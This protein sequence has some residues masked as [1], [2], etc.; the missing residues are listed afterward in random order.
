MRDSL[1]SR[2]LAAMHAQHT[3]E[4]ILPL[5]KLTQDG[6]QDSIRLVPNTEPITHQGEVYAPLAFDVTLPTEEAE[7]TPVVSWTADNTD[8]R[9]IEA[10]RSVTGVVKARIVWVLASTPD[11]VELELNEVEMREAQYDASAV[12]GTMGVEPILDNRFGRK[13][14]NPKSFPGLF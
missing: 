1:S 4:V 12:T 8:L 3:D 6:W 5:V 9:M 11:V 13:S 14:F 2:M 10:L 7:G